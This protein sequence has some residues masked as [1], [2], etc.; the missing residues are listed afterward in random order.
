MMDEIEETVMFRL[1]S[2]LASLLYVVSLYLL[3]A[4]QSSNDNIYIL[5]IYGKSYKQ[6]RIQFLQ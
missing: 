2:W 3:S 5:S 1:A 4:I 6:F